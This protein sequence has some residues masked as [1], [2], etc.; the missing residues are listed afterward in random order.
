ML[1]ATTAAVLLLAAATGVAG[2]GAMVDPL[3]RN[4]IDRNESSRC[5]CA[6]ATGPC[7]NGQSCYWYN[8][9][10]FIGCPTCDSISG[11]VQTDL[12]GLGKKATIN[13]PLQRTVNRN[14][15]AGSEYD[16][17]MHNPWRAP[18]V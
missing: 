2:H 10:C 15:T 12:C 9:G 6:N 17:Y 5:P 13:D 18:G 7:N 11:R 8:Q 14:A 16:I 4:A 1:A 3:P